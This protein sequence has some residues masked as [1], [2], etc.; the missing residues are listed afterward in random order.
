M[1]LDIPRYPDHARLYDVIDLDT[2]RPLD[3]FHADDEAGLYRTYR[4]VESASGPTMIVPEVHRGRIRVVPRAE[5]PRGRA[6]HA[7]EPVEVHGEVVP[8]DRGIAA[9]VRWL[10]ALPGVRTLASCE[11]APPGVNVPYVQFACDREASLLAVL[12]SL[13][14]AAPRDALGIRPHVGSVEAC[15]D[16]GRLYYR[17]TWPDREALAA[18]E[19]S[20]D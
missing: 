15:E 2:G 9:A 8:V 10:N 14:R 17:L 13:R 4:V 5:S 12:L 7:A 20:R 18:W 11:G 16:E 3:V 1:I 6:D 19:R